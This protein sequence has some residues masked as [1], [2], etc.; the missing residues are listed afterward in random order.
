M[1]KVFI[2]DLR[3]R[4]IIG[5][6]D[7]EREKAQDIILNLTLFADLKPAGES[8]NINDCIDY[9]NIAHQVMRFTETAKAY[10]VEALAEGIAKL[11][12]ADSRVQIVQVKIEKPGAITNA[13]S[14]GIEI[15]RKQPH[16][17]NPF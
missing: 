9:A 8:D 2:Q 10:T 14:A 17:E 6:Y 11:C 7:W 15:T 13:R 1:D 5:I 16:G 12:L 4:G 3:L